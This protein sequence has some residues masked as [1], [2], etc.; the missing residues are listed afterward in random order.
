[1]ASDLASDFQFSTASFD[2][3]IRTRSVEK[4]LEPLISSVR[5]CKLSILKVNLLL[6]ILFHG[7]LL[8]FI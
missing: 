5:I 4:F 3:R 7:F 8:T 6:N 2:N 1:M